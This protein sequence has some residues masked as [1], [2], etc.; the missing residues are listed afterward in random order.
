MTTREASTTPRKTKATTNTGILPLR[1]AQCQ[2]D[3]QMGDDRDCGLDGA[4]A[5]G[6]G[7]VFLEALHHCIGYAG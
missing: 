7:S 6:D 3:D 5:G 1:F 2:N 4:R